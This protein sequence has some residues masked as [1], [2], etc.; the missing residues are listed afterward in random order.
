MRRRRRRRRR[1]IRRRSRSRRRERAN[2]PARNRAEWP[3]KITA[4]PLPPLPLFSLSL[5]LSFSCLF[6]NEPNSV[7][8]ALPAPISTCLHSVFPFVCLTYLHTHTH[9]HT[10]SLTHTLVIYDNSI[11]R[12]FVRISVNIHASQSRV[13]FPS[14]PASLKHL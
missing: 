7:D 4:L 10:L 5:S 9:T 2:N 8:C 14:Y 6:P 13:S 3:D 1:R 12:M 11:R